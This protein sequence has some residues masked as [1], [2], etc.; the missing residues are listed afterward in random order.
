MN[1]VTGNLREPLAIDRE[2]L[3]EA[4]FAALRDLLYQHSG[5]A[6]ATHKL[7]MVQ[8]R[9][10]KRLRAVGVGTYEAYLEV[11]R[12]PQSPEWGEFINALTTNLTS[13]FREGHHFVRLPELL[14]PFR[15][16]GA[17]LRVW[18]AGCSTGEEPYTIAMTLVKAFGPSLQA[19]VLATDL[20][21]AVLQ[22]AARGVY[23]LARVDGLDE[24]WKRLA[25]LKGKGAHGGQVKV[26]PE[27][28]RL[29]SFQQLNFK[30]STWPLEGGPFHAIFC[31]NVMIYFDKPTQRELLGRFH[32]LLVPA[33]LLF[34]G[35]SEA[36]LDTTLGFQSLGQTIYRKKEG[37]P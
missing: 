17:R 6:L 37:R 5:I 21:T 29:I 23:P 34:V 9:L 25:F 19:Q 1:R 27:I 33:G 2:P 13:F 14:D 4:T 15:T 30:D 12:D 24:A 36:L 28:Q 7:T 10:A 11:L 8:S 31:R 22:T 18:S 26:K 3:T 32:R 35:H 16:P 20:D